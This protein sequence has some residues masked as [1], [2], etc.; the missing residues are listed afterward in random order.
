VVPPPRKKIKVEIMDIYNQLPRTN[1]GKCDE[2]G[3]YSFAIRLMA[4][5]VTLDKSALLMEPRYTVNKE[6]LRVLTAYN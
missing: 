6:H 3:C 5:E 4:G 2:Q 1:C